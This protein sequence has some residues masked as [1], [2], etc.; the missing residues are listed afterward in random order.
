M[1]EILKL[2][3]KYYT[4]FLQFFYNLR[5]HDVES[6]LYNN[7]RDPKFITEEHKF[8]SLETLVLN[9]SKTC[10]VCKHN[11]GSKKF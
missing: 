9:E 10:I 3:S 6:Y 1:L 8:F 11:L 5:F 7:I 4:F 2:I